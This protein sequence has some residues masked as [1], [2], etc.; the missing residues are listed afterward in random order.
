MANRWATVTL[1]EPSGRR[2]SVDLVASSVFDAAHLFVAHAM[3]NP[4]NG[5][6]R[7]T[8]ESVLEVIVDGKVHRVEGQ[9]L[10]RWI[11]RERNE[12][13]GPAGYVFGKRP[14]LDESRGKGRRV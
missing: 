8:T 10:Q 5:L 1:I 11:L 6:P 3:E 4:R 2:W 9:A 13:G 7:P 14:L 12:R